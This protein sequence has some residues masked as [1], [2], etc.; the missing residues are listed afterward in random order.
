MS[1]SVDDAKESL[2][3]VEATMDASR[4][5]ASYAGTDWILLTWGVIWFVGFLS[6]HFL[7]QQQQSLA[8]LIK[9]MWIGLLAIG[10]V[11]SFWAGLRMPIQNTAGKRIGILWGA[12]YAY[13]WLGIIIVWPSLNFKV[14]EPG[15]WGKCIGAINALIPMFAWVVMGL[16]LET[17]YL[18][19]LGLLLS[20][21]IAVG[22]FLFHGIFYLWMAFVCGGIMIVAGIYLCAQ[23]LRARKMLA[24][25]QL[26][27]A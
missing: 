10:I 23:C 14:L 2:K 1:I 27:N 16:W 15:E 12:I 25:E 22:F 11:M 18:A 6:S 26:Q 9:P 7:V 8:F 19:W 17:N 4:T 5:L 21:L 20:A 3:Q 24:K 13:V